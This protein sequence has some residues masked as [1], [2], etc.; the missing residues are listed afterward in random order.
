MVASKSLDE[1]TRNLLAFTLPRF[2]VETTFV[3]LRDKTA[4]RAGIRNN[5]CMVFGQTVGQPR[6]DLFDI[7]Q[8]AEIAHEQQV[9][10]VVDATNSTPCLCQPFQLGADII[11]HSAAGYLSGH[12]IVVGGLLV[13]SG[14]FDWESSGR[15]PLLTEACDAFHGLDFFEEFGTAAFLMHARMIGLR[16]FGA[17]MSP[18]S[19]FQILQGIE[20]LTLRMERHVATTRQLIDFLVNQDAVEWVA[21]PD[22]PS[23]PDHDIAK[24]Q[25]PMGSGAAFNFC[26]RGGREAGQKLIDKLQLFTRAI[27]FGSSK[28]LII[29]PAS[30]V[31]FRKDRTELESEGF[32][33]GLVSISVGLE[34]IRDLV[35]DLRRGLRASQE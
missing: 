7:R 19:A 34:D 29:H 4:T 9:P 15:F 18:T 33:E 17:C 28:S 26:V 10:L 16:D 2:G 13:D 23:H 3:D 6:L 32:S 24:K 27:N 31:H 14:R 1:A 5:T 22:L 20:T 8:I 30:T 11:V 35:A 12:G 25:F 21:F